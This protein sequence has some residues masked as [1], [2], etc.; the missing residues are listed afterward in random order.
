MIHQ[1]LHAPAITIKLNEIPVR[2][3]ARAKPWRWGIPSPFRRVLVGAFFLGA[4]TAGA[5]ADVV[6]DWNIAMTDYATPRD[7][8]GALAPYV[9]TRAYAMAHIAML[10]AIKEA[11]GR[12]HDVASPEAAA[13]QAAHDVLVHEFADGAA[14]FNALLATQLGAISDG[15]AKTSGVAVGAEEA[16]EMLAARANDGSATGEGPYTHGSNPG[17]YQFTPPFDSTPFNGYAAGVNWGKVRPFVMKD[18]DQFRAPAPYK[19]TDLDYTFDL[20]EIKT[21]GS[22]HS[23]GRTDDQTQLAI[24]W[25]ESTGLGWNRIARLLAAQSPGDLYR[26]ASLLYRSDQAGFSI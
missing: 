19:V 26:S 4:A 11:A 23:V 13:A 6:I 3:P 2:S 7:A 21:L 17:D 12:H 10:K 22:L 1:S 5:R 9:E 14:G 24:F 25:Y 20:N 18:D 16:A 8:V 15:P